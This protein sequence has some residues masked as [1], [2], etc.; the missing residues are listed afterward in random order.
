MLLTLPA[1][2]SAHALLVVPGRGALPGPLALAAHGLRV[3]HPPR[4]GHPRNGEYCRVKRMLRRT[5]L[6]LWRYSLRLRLVG[7]ML[8]IAA[9]LMAI[10]VAFYYQTEKG[11]Y[12]EFARQNEA[13]SKAV[14]VALEGTAGRTPADFKNLDN[15]LQQLDI[16]GRPGNFGHQQRRP[17]RRQHQCRQRRQVDH[18]MAQATD[19]QGPARRNR[20]RRGTVLQR[21][22]A[23]RSRQPSR[24]V[25]SI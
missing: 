13:L 7:I 14:Q 24:S 10:L 16:R 15:Y 20:D 4:A 25:S 18:R 6:A 12:N 23:G 3:G 5:R 21:D 9:C 19:H 1:A 2:G 8:F 17:H 11:F 22:P